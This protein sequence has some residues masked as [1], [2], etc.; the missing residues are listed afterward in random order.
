M[1]L[2]KQINQA[3]TAVNVSNADNVNQVVELLKLEASAIS[4]AA[5]RLQGEQVNQALNLL[6]TCQGKVV[7]AGVGKSGIVA[8]KIAATLNS[9]GT[10]AICLHPCDALHGDLGVVTANDVAILL[11]NSGETEEILGMLPH[12]QY[13][14]VAI[15]AIV[16]NLKSTL[17]RKADVVIDAAV[18]RE[19][20]PHNLAPTTSTTVALAIGDALAMTVMQMKGLTPED[21]ALNHPAGRLGKRLTLRVATI[22]HD[23]DRCATLSPDAAWLEIVSGISKG[24]LGAAPVVDNAGK[25]LGIITDG[26]L[27]RTIEHTE[28]SNIKA[29]TAMAIMTREPIVV[30]ADT[31]AYDALQ[32]ME[33]RPSQ[34]S[35]LPVVDAEH[36]CLGL[37]RVH[38]VVR[39]GL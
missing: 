10:V 24:G 25:L 29:L 38:D 8:Q 20:C 28:L 27:R 3:A 18:A 6:A 30:T 39:S 14:K 26:D 9:V 16:G 1:Q 2:V 33:N 19:A 35:V 17:A 7:L 34:I 11:S 5:D 15:M 31:L 37:L 12:L 36:N 13:R 22:M 4:Q 21:F 32:L 23:I